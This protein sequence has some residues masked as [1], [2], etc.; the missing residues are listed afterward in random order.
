MSYPYSSRSFRSREPQYRRN[1]K[2][3]AREV[4]VIDESKQQL[5]VMS[6]SDALRLAQ[7]KGLDLLETVP[8]AN[9][10]VCRVVN[11]G[12]FQYEEAK[13]AKD[14][15]G[16]Q[17]SSRMKELQL[18][19]VIAVHDFDTKL[20]HAIEFLSADMKVCVKLRFRGRQRAHKEF[21]FEVVNKFVAHT[22]AYGRADSP[23]KLLGE[24][25]LTVVISPLPRDKR[26]KTPAAT[27]RPAARPAT[28]SSFVQ[29]TATPDV[30]SD[31]GPAD[32]GEG[33]EKIEA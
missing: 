12:K 22:A 29:A 28:D 10:P 9:P 30:P 24:R 15:H 8:N 27:T 4:R 33:A 32:Q 3:R 5:G 16:R 26:P 21:G 2:I 23:P 18:S 13:R 14:A 11:Y 1:G 31:P 25:D 7:S 20:A 17:A 19:P 6:L